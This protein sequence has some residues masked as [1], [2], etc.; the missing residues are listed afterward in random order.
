MDHHLR[1]SNKFLGR[2]LDKIESHHPIPAKFPPWNWKGMKKK[3]ALGSKGQELWS[4]WTFHFGFRELF[5]MYGAA[6][7]GWWGCDQISISSNHELK[8]WQT[9]KVPA[10][11]SFGDRLG[12]TKTYFK[13]YFHDQWLE[14][15]LPQWA[16]DTKQ[17]L[18]ATNPENETWKNAERAEAAKP[19]STKRNQPNKIL[20]NCSF[21]STECGLVTLGC[22]SWK[23]EPG[24]AEHTENHAGAK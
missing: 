10:P 6:L 16:S 7:G 11:G 8:I 17:H 15:W 18:S 22:Q 21:K 2:K 14:H 4:S 19:I 13:P 9:K 5:T 24:K 3:T 12:F 20:R 1:L 23:V